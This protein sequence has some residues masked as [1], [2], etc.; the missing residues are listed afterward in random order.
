MDASDLIIPILESTV[1]V[2]TEY[3]KACNRSY[4]HSKDFEYAMKFCAMNLVGKHTGT[5]FPELDED[6]DD[7][8][9]LEEVE[10]HAD[11]FTRYEGDHEVLQ[12][13]NRSYDTW[14]EW[15]PENI[16]ESILKN[17]IDNS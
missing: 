5:I 15:E 9:E 8:T 6:S 3:S 14:D 2:A 1:V 4:V 11:D 16:I 12:A 13:V 17:S 7:E 10:E